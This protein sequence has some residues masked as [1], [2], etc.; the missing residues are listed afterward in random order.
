M[1][2]LPSRM[3][4]PHF[5][6]GGKISTIEKPV[7]EPGPGQL[8]VRV[9]ANA[10]CGSERPQYWNGTDVTPGHEAAGTVVAAGTG[11][12]TPV[13]TNGGIFLMDFCRE[14]RNCQAGYT[15]QCLAKRG[16]MGFNRDG[17]YGAYELIHENIFFPAEDLTATEATLLLDVMGTG[18]HAIKR[19]QR[20]HDDIRTI[21]IP[22]AG[23]VGL[24]I[25]A[26][27]RIM[28]G[29]EVKIAISDVVPYR[30]KMAEEL[31]GL[32]ILTSETTL[33]EGLK[34]HGI[35]AP[36]VAIDAAGREDVRDECM[37][38][39]VHRGVMVAVAHGGGLKIASLYGDFTAREMTLIG[40]EYFAYHELEENYRLLKENRDYLNGIITHRMG[41]DEIER[42]FELFWSGE[43]GKVVI[44]Q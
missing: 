25:L 4:V 24:G 22:G 11:T 43:T 8:L 37:A 15:N 33:A 12:T 20:A 32:P 7:L 6:G 9:R 17:G 1:S 31:G 34:R 40:S 27:A 16:D 2:A 26:M 10:L 41:V 38:L 28:L 36:D 42:A 3:T 44:E 39:L 13:G 18:G 5:V 21:L 23:P 30:L 14:C 19:A 35:D 29:P